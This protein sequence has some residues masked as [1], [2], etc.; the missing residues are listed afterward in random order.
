MIDDIDLILE[1]KCRHEHLMV[2]QMIKNPPAMQETRVQSLGQEDSLEEGMAS[3]SSILAWRIPWTEEPNRLYIVHGVA[4]SRTWLRTKTF[5]FT[6]S[7]QNQNQVKMQIKIFWHPCEFIKELLQCSLSTVTY[8]RLWPQ[9]YTTV[10][11]DI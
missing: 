6:L 9:F 5:T 10:Q 7:F 8:D 11:T 2:A 3:Y 4:K 1:S